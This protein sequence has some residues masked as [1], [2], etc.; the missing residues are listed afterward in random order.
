MRR[1]S[2]VG[3][4]QVAD[5]VTALVGLGVASTSLYRAA[6]LKPSTLR[7]PSARI[8]AGV[9]V[10]LLEEAQRR[11]RDPLIGLRAGACAEPRGPLAYLLMSSPR[12]ADG[13]RHFARFAPL[14]IDTLRIEVELGIDTAS[15]VYDLRDPT[16]ADQRHV[17]DY[18]LMATLRAMRRAV[19]RELQV[20]EIHVRHPDPGY[21]DDEERAFGCPI[22]YARRRIRVVFPA[23]E[24]RA[25]ARLANPL[26]AEQ[27]EKFAAALLSRMAAPT[28]VSGRVADVLRSTF[29]SGVRAD[30]TTVARRLGMSDRTLQR[31]LESERTTFR[32]LRDD[33]LW[34]MVE[35]LLSNPALKVEAVALSAGFG[36]V[37]AFSRAFKRRTGSSPTQYRRRLA[38]QPTTTRT[39]LPRRG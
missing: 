34:G 11:T 20:R 5:L 18:L 28:T 35:A 7:D 22:R 27:I 19:G 36:E 12:L 6:G 38:R 1:E 37:A 8:P 3:G 39:A 2:T 29:A 14:V 15:I 25:K 31:S 10:A 23:S 16:L 33:V 4:L 30:R 21:A 26:I 32:S 9:V 24:L 17:V 13:V